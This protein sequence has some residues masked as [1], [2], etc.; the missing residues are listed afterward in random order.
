MQD[1]PRLSTQIINKLFL[2]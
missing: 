2:N 1:D